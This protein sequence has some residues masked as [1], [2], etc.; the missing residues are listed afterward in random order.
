MKL[1]NGLY[2]LEEIDLPQ[3]RDSSRQVTRSGSH[4]Q[5]NL[6]VNCP[7]AR[8]WWG[9]SVLGGMNAGR[10]RYSGSSD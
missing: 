3:A 10:W 8:P 7:R 1:S 5:G 2:L 6:P 4:A 9:L